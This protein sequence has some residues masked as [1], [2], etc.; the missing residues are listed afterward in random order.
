MPVVFYLLMWIGIDFAILERSVCI[1]LNI[2]LCFYYTLVHTLKLQLI[3]PTL[4]PPPVKK[5]HKN[6]EHLCLLLFEIQYWKHA[7]R[8]YYLMKCKSYNSVKTVS[9]IKNQKSLMAQEWKTY[10]PNSPNVLYLS[11]FKT[12]VSI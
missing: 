2:L 5:S 12:R 6:N 4:P 1:S 10:I 3:P 9:F 8:L 7:F 11:K